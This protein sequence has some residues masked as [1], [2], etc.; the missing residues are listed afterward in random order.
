MNSETPKENVSN[1]N[2]AVISTPKI[3][4]LV[5]IYN[6]AISTNSA[7]VAEFA[8]DALKGVANA[9]GTAA[10]ARLLAR[11]ADNL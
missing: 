3:D 5:D 8:I 2:D 1:N 6:K 10:E 11:I 9:E 7:A 4:Y